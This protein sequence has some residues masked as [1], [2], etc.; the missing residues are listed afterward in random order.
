MKDVPIGLDA[1]GTRK[2]FDS[3]GTVEVPADK[4]YGAQTARSLVHFSIGGD[5]MPK[6][7]YH[8]YGTVKKAC[9]LVNQAEGRLPGWK[10]EAILRA[11][12]ETIRGELD[13]HYPL[14][15]WQTGSG[16]QSNMNVNEVLANRASELLGGSRGEGRLDGGRARPGVADDVDGIHRCSSGRQGVGD[17]APTPSH[18]PDG[19]PSSLRRLPLSGA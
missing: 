16:T 3:M 10:A 5:R 2:E 1:A 9:A 7:V 14:F 6:A 13:D 15:V 4:Y 18:A 12:D 19:R 11:A 17:A 8:A